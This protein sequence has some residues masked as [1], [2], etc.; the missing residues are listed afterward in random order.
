VSSPLHSLNNDMFIRYIIFALMFVLS[1]GKLKLWIF[2]NLTEDVGFL[3]SFM[4]VYDY[5]YTGERETIDTKR[6][7]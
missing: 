5:T 4:P 1:A 2:P 3:E 7:P 6:A